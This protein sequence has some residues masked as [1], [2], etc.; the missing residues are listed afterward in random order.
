VND[1]HQVRRG[2][3]L[4]LFQFDAGRLNDTDEVLEGLIAADVPEQLAE[5]SL[6]VAQSA[7]E[8]RATG[9]AIV[10]ELAPEWPVHRQ[11]NVD[12]SL[13]RLATWEI[14]TGHA[15][16]KV[17]I[18]EAVELAREFST[19]HSGAFVNGVLDRYWKRLDQS[20]TTPTADTDG[21]L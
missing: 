19:E 13:L 2:A 15:P 1:R 18:D 3:L 20:A 16:P 10:S 12:R 5:E 9:D 11:P 7:W 21:A 17:V 14:R 8:D 4:A 6:R